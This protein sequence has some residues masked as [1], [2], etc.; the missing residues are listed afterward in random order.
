MGWEWYGTGF[1]AGFGRRT[2]DD[3][4]VYYIDLSTLVYYTRYDFGIFGWERFF[5]VPL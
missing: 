3:I 5:L 1:L 2:V 4:L